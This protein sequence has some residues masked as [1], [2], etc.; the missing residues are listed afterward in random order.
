MNRGQAT[1][2]LA[3]FSGAIPYFSSENEWR[4]LFASDCFGLCER[5]ETGRLD[6]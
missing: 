3:I 1:H 4:L 5:L 2:F 6:V